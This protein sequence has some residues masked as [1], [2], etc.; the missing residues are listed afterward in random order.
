[1]PNTLR[2]R[3]DRLTPARVFLVVVIPLA[4]LYFAT[5]AKARPYHIDPLTNV[6]TAWQI[7]AQGSVY[8]DEYPTL[9]TSE[10]FGNIGWF[11]TTKTGHT[12]SK[13]PPGAALLAAP[14]YF[15]HQNTTPTTLTGSN[16]FSVPSIALDL[17]SF[18]PAAAA[19]SLATAMAIGFLAL[20]FLP[21]LTPSTTIVGAYVAGLGTGAWSVASDAL[22]QH[23]PAML[24]IALALY[25][26]SRHHPWLAGLSFGMAILT[27]PHLA[28]IAAGVGIAIAISERSVKPAIQ[29]GAGSVVGF[30]T[31]VAYNWS[32]F[33]SPSISGGYGANFSENALHSSWS[34]YLHNIYGAFLDPVR[35]LFVWAPFVLVLAFGFAKAWRPAPAWAKGAAIGGLLYLLLQLKANRF[36]GGGGF[37]AYRYP[38]EAL[39]AMAPLLALSWREWIRNHTWRTGLFAVSAAFAIA[40]QAV[41]S[42]YH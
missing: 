35:G 24:W 34:W 29:V 25:L 42:V 39:T 16:D 31:L 1:M 2:S 26:T 5:A 15:L 20:T 13:Y 10:S 22:W 28:L 11:V 19:A 41:A 21:Y 18:V 33:G 27:R 37:F 17:P 38:L 6:L 36:T 3:L 40:A 12:V 14:L 8:L 23:G 7:G 9:A 32:V 4:I 30:G